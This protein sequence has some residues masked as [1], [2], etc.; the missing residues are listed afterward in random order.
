[1][2]DKC[3]FIYNIQ[4]QGQAMLD[5]FLFDPCCAKKCTSELQFIET[6]LGT[7]KEKFLIHPIV[8]IFLKLKWQKTWPLYAIYVAFFKFFFISL[9]GY[10]LSW[11]GILSGGENMM[12]F[13]GAKSAW[14]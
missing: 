3:S 5:F 6:I 2:V 4:V 7:R 10:S 9:A 8:Q 1:M 12:V 11:Y 13:K 14:R